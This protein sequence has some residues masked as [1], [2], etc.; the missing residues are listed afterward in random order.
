MSYLSS[1]ERSSRERADQAREE[2][3]AWVREDVADCLNNIERLTDKEAAFV[4]NCNQFLIS[5]RPLSNKQIEWLT[6]LAAR[7]YRESK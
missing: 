2:Q 3:E 5:G 4:R 6:N 7:F 1:K